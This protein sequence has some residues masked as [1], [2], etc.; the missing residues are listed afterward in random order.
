MSNLEDSFENYN[1]DSFHEDSNDDSYD[2][3]LDTSSD[4]YGETFE[5]DFESEDDQV[6][7]TS[8][9]V[10][11][12]KTSVENVETTEIPILPLVFAVKYNPPTIVLRYFRKKYPK[13]TL[14]YAVEL[15]GVTRSSNS[16]G[17]LYRVLGKLQER[18]GE[19]CKFDKQQLHALVKK[20]L[21]SAPQPP[22]FMRKNPQK[23]PL[24]FGLKFNPPAIA[25]QYL[26]SVKG[27]KGKIPK[28][29]VLRLPDITQSSNI[30]SAFERILTAL[31]GHFGS[32][33][34][35]T[36][37]EQQ[38]R[39]L[40]CR[41][42]RNSPV[43]LAASA[44]FGSNSFL[45]LS[46]PTF[47]SS[48]DFSLYVPQLRRIRKNIA[49][50]SIQH[51][52]RQI[53]G[54]SKQRKHFLSVVENRFSHLLEVTKQL[55]SQVKLLISK[56]EKDVD[57]LSIE[58][59]E[60]IDEK[61]KDLSK[62]IQLMDEKLNSHLNKNKNQRNDNENEIGK[63]GKN[64]EQLQL[65]S[66]SIQMLTERFHFNNESGERSFEF[67]TKVNQELELKLK[68]VTESVQMLSEELNMRAKNQEKKEEEIVTDLQRQIEEIDARDKKTKESLKEQL[69]EILDRFRKHEEIQKKRND[70][71]YEGINTNNIE[72]QSQLD[73]M[74]NLPAAAI[75]IVDCLYAGGTKEM[76]E[77]NLIEG[78]DNKNVYGELSNLAEKISK[79]RRKV[80][81]SPSS[82]KKAER[83][84]SKT[85]L[86]SP[87][88]EVSQQISEIRS[89]ISKI[90]I[91]S[92]YSN[93]ALRSRTN[94][95]P[96]IIHPKLYD[97]DLIKNNLHLTR[98]QPSSNKSSLFN[99][100]R[101]RFE[102]EN[103]LRV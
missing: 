76:Y 38:L 13:E 92:K 7:A 49:V 31:R 12:E 39:S 44:N 83:T 62:S 88:T 50:R 63:S 4:I 14:S 102:V 100:K 46:S 89:R 40:V 64:D 53:W 59:N 65:L 33:D 93:N 86:L 47:R 99:A 68:M 23:Q 56:D 78:K 91:N 82:A 42:I 67:A 97:I 55:E 71:L 69:Q 75:T 29:L 87:V 9:N 16:N 54:P 95:P 57:D 6:Q 34:A 22:T 96:F 26:D 10:V 61:L 43:S 103:N 94:P 8:Q 1:S 2:L 85:V 27:K 25:L 36:I 70:T 5:E 35:Y 58:K 45:K 41:L 21:Q 90:H 84:I 77:G 60:H 37:D 30:D 32:F 98:R 15:R 28:S 51:W 3:D 66:S 17:V 19:K 11:S 79:H 73:A 24:I 20:V 72:I 52:W 18:F 48:S 74:K 80:I 81:E 101:L